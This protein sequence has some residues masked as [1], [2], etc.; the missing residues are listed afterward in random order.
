MEQHPVPRNISGFQFHLIGDMTL[1]QF[2]YL[3]AGAMAGYVV[4]RLNLFPGVFNI[5][6][7]ICCGLV[8]FAFAFIPIQDR[9]LEKWIAAFIRSILSPTQYLWRKENLPPDILTQPLIIHRQIEKTPQM[10]TQKEAQVKLQ[11]YLATLPTLPHE[12]INLAEKQYIQKTLNMFQTSS[13]VSASPTVHIPKPTFSP[14][15][16]LSQVRPVTSTLQPKP[17]PTVSIKTVSAQTIPPVS[18]ANAPPVPTPVVKPINTPIISSTQPAASVS[19]IPPSAFTPAVT[20]ATPSPLPINPKPTVSIPVGSKPVINVHTQKPLPDLI[21]PMQEQVKK[22][23]QEKA[24]LEKELSSLR[25]SFS[26]QKESMFVKPTPAHETAEPTVKTMTAKQ[27]VSGAG[28]PSLPGYPN[29]VIG[30]VKDPGLRLLPNIIITIKDKKSMPLRALKTNKLGQFATA[31]PLPD[32]VYILE[33]EDP[34]KRFFF[35]IP[36]I[37]LNGKVFLPIEII[38]KGQKEIMRAQLSKEIFGGLAA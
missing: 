36:E 25:E 33:L 6:L 23:S 18:H 28:M 31:T 15:D 3:A 30:V 34:L 5:G 12:T 11:A 19:S 37:T 4:F 22:L 17:T 35:D 1:R 32:G 24:M 8:G 26:K 14:T 16:P 27:A 38:A 21:N 13:A 29:I 20:P 9:P 7:G 2:G 10:N